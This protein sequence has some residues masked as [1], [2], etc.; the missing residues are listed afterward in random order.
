MLGLRKLAFRKGNL[1]ASQAGPLLPEAV[2]AP[3]S[4]QPGQLFAKRLVDADGQSPVPFWRAGARPIDTR[5]FP[6]EP[7]VSQFEFP[8]STQRIRVLLLYRRFWQ[9][10]AQSK[11]WRD[12]EIIVYDRK[13]VT[14]SRDAGQ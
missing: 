3:W 4:R 9:Q 12:N 10:V 7:V 13:I 6:G 11:S 2:G 8:R 5:L 14:E 1:V